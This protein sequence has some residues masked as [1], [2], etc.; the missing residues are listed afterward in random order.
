MNKKRGLR[1]T[2]PEICVGPGLGRDR[3]S[4][5]GTSTTR[6]RQTQNGLYRGMKKLI[7]SLKSYFIPHF[8]VLDNKH[9]ARDDS[10]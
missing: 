3:G 10:S 2:R 8:H 7:Y 1:T 6:L 9:K 4:G 5:V